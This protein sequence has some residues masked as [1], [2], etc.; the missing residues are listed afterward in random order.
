MLTGLFC[1]WLSWM[2]IDEVFEWFKPE[3]HYNEDGLDK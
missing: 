1:I 3:L 2:V